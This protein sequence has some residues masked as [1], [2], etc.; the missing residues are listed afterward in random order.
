MTKKDNNMTI[1]IMETIKDLIL[2]IVWIYSQCLEIKDFSMM[3]LK[4]VFSET[5]FL[6]QI[7]F[8]RINPNQF[9]KQILVKDL[10]EEWVHQKVYLNRL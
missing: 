8:S 7:N 2:W 3:L 5:I 10:V 9:L 1:L 4:I 6:A